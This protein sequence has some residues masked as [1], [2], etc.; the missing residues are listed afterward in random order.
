MYVTKNA[1]RAT[2]VPQISIDNCQERNTLDW[3]YLGKSR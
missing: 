1:K 2:Y 3:K